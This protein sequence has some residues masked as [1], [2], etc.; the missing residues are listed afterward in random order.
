MAVQ[1]VNNPKV[2]DNVK[3]E[4]GNSSDLQIYH[5]GSNSYIDDSGT[6]DL[7]IRANNLRLSNADGSGQFINAN[8]GGAV[9]LYH[10]NSKKFETTSS[11]VQVSSNL[12]FNGS[13]LISSNT[14]DGS[15][16]AQIVI[17][18]GGASGDTRG[19]SVHMAGNEHA[20]GGLLQLRAGSGSVSEIRSYTNGSERM[21]IDS[22]GNVGIG[23][24]PDAAVRLSVSGQ[25]GTTNGTAA[26]PTHTFYGDDDTGMFRAAANN[27]AFSSGG[28]ERMRID[29]AGDVGIGTTDPGVKFQVVGASAT[30]SNA[31]GGYEL[32][33]LIDT[34]S[35]AA[36]K[37]GG[38][39]FGGNFNSLSLSFFH[40][41][42]KSEW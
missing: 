25:I 32:M 28:S 9:E 27:L 31:N 2:G 16:N 3:I 13:S 36:N 37:G 41:K 34:A 1:F 18:G 26:A 7:Y 39:G 19:A 30:P 23:M 21:R 17:S 40:I 33:Q 5:D 11:G 6:G 4:V 29:S 24:T 42:I 15:D 35:Q 12:T 22:S 8:N 38:V 10:N 14:A 20:N